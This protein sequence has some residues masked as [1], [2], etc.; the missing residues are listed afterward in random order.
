M[1][2]DSKESSDKERTKKMGRKTRLTIQMIIAGL[3]VMLTTVF[4]FTDSF[5]FRQTVETVA[6]DDLEDGYYIGTGSG[7]GGELKVE[8]AVE[9]GEIVDVVVLEHG[10]SDGVSDPAFEQLPDAI[11]AANSADVDTVSGAT[12]T[13][14]GLK[15]AVN[16]ALS[17]E[18]N[19]TSQATGDSET[20]DEE[21]EE[22]AKEIEAMTFD[23][24]DGTYEG[25]AEGH[26]GPVTVEVILADGKIT[27]VNVLEHEETEGAS[28][29]AIEQVPADIVEYQ[30]TKVDIVSGV[31]YSSNAIMDAVEN[32]LDLGKADTVYI[33]GSYEGTA[34][35]HNGPLTVEVLV[36]EGEIADVEIR[37]HNET[38]GLADPAIEEVSMAI[39]EKNRPDVNVDIVSGATVTSEAIIEAVTQALEDAQ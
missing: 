25:T 17:G 10:E 27:E 18:P 24:E 7:Y 12:M 15:T 11:I 21:E 16:N 3:F 4:I 31:T 37:E 19:E 28:D 26:N 35:G 2:L 30:S 22:D 20:T 6:T 5:G 29:P 8:V 33:D 13:S 38:E 39:V 23:M 9:N 1:T 14:E 32:A 36:E 34:E